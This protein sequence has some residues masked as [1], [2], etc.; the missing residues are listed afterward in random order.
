MNIDDLD[1]RE[2]RQLVDVAVSVLGE[3]LSDAEAEELSTLLD[4]AEVPDGSDVIRALSDPNEFE[5]LTKRLLSEAA[6]DD[7]AGSELLDVYE[8]RKSMMALDA[9][10][11]TG[12]VLL[13]I[14]LL[15]LKKVQIGKNGV[16]VEFGPMQLSQLFNLGGQQGP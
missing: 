4:E 14:V 8:D 15:R 13:A 3:R 7:M 10:L 1:R 11:I 9:G 5:P 12:P 16:D 6:S 2:L